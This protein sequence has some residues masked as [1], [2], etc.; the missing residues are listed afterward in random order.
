MLKSM[1]MQGG[2]AYFDGMECRVLEV[3]NDSRVRLSMPVLD[4]RL[5]VLPLFMQGICRFETPQGI[6][7]AKAEV[8]ERYK[9]ENRYV[10]EMELKDGLYHTDVEEEP[11]LFC[12]EEVL[13]SFGSRTKYHVEI[14]VTALASG[15]LT[16]CVAEGQA[17]P[18]EQLEA[19]QETG[20][21]TMR[22]MRLLGR[23]TEVE[24]IHN[25]QVYHFSFEGM[26]IET[27]KKLTEFILLGGNM[28]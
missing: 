16:F 2:N 14:I 5:Q 17:L 4:G 23:V 9:S 25:R 22:Q 1:I 19:A 10:M 28:L 11:V 20:E 13:F 12:N 18:E 3:L 26:P 7:Y 27:R 21:V 8:L 6:Y 15:E 24:T